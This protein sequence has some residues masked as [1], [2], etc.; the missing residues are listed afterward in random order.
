ML[1]RMCFTESTQQ[2]VQKMF[3]VLVKLI[4][5][6]FSQIPL[7]LKASVAFSYS[8]LKSMLERT[9]F[10]PSDHLSNPFDAYRSIICFITRIHFF[11]NWCYVKK[12]L[13]Y[14]EIWKFKDSLIQFVNTGKQNVFFFRILIGV[15]PTDTLSEG[16]FFTIFLTVASEAC[17]KEHLLFS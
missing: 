6:G 7:V 8:S 17:W 15:S 10:D 5:N 16:N 9:S 3:Y 12:V 1:C 11:K 4:I 14:L 13:M 2:L